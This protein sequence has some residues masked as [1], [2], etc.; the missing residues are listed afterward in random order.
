MNLLSSYFSRLKSSSSLCFQKLNPF[1]SKHRVIL[2]GTPIQNN[3]K[4]L[5]TLL[6]FLDNSIDIEQLDLD[7]KELKSTDQITKLHKLIAPRMLRR[8]KCDVFKELPG[9][10]IFFFHH[11]L[12]FFTNR[13]D[14]VELIV[15]I[16]MTK[17]QKELYKSI[18]EKNYEVLS[19]QEN[20]LGH[21]LS[22]IQKCV[23]HPFL[24]N[25]IEPV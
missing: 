21:V 20:K 4:E 24:F 12:F 11:F 14:K 7:F 13:V 1:K 16:F 3:V 2:T 8:L 18:L 25:D 22:A 17:M 5:I 6:N 23:N 19:A 9:I 15:P 10:Y